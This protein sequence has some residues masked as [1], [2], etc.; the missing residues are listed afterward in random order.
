M[1]S[2]ITR[3]RR[4][5]LTEV[6]PLSFQRLEDRQLLA[7]VV[8]GN[9]TDLTNADTSS[10]AALIANDGGD[11]ISLREAVEASNNTPGSDTITFDGSVFTGGANSLVRLTGGELGITEDLTIDGSTGTDIVITGDRAG[12]DTTLPGTFITDVTA[13]LGGL[14]LIH[15]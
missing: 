11:G 8:V 3:R 13:G 12:D 2:S 14:S 10:I 1:S 7:G 9:A 15:I 5:A 4:L 6:N